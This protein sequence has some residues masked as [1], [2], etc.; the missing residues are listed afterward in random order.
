MKKTLLWSATFAFCLLLCL[1]ASQGQTPNSDSQKPRYAGGKLVRPEDYREWIFLSSGLGM[2]YNPAPGSHEMFTNVFVPQWAYRQFLATGKWPDKAMFV[3]EDRGSQS[4]GSINKGGH[5]QAD[6]M[7]LGVE[8][9][10]EN[11]FP[12]KWAYFNFSADTKTAEANPKAACWQCHD[13][14]AAVEHTFVQFYPTLKQVAKKFGT[15]RAA[16]EDVSTVK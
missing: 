4:E 6:L 1:T 7:Q 14:H 9:K 2:T 15:Y 3:V 12:D 8:V 16:A 10:D 5:F 11:Q 13:D